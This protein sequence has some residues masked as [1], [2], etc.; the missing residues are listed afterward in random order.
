MFIILERGREKKG[1]YTEIELDGERT[2]CES[3]HQGR[4]IERNRDG[5]K[6]ETERD[7]SR[8]QRVNKCVKTGST[9]RVEPV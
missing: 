7:T 6:I 2:Q 4:K 5:A 3:K 1:R 8:K 9:R